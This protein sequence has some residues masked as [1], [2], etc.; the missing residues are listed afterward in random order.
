VATFLL[1]SVQVLIVIE[2]CGLAWIRLK[3]FLE[4][5]S[6]FL[7]LSRN[8]VADPQPKMWLGSIG[9]E[10]Q[11]SNKLLRPIAKAIS[12]HRLD[13][14]AACEAAKSFPFVAAPQRGKKEGLP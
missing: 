11:C 4:F 13:A 1:L 14:R 10:L 12:F 2:R 3:N 9:L 5:F 7:E 8:E 6:R